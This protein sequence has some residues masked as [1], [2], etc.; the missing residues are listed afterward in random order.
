MKQMLVC[1]FMLLLLAGCGNSGAKPPEAREQNPAAPEVLEPAEPAAPAELSLYLE[2]EVYDPSLTR[3]T[4]FLENHTDKSVKFGEDYSIQFFSEDAWVDLRPRPSCGTDAIGYRISSG[5]TMALNCTLERYE[6]VP[7]PGRYR[8]VKQVDGHT[9]YAEFSLGESPYTAEAPYGFPPL[10]DLPG[11]YGADTTENNCVVF[12]GGGI[13]H[14]ET[15]ENFL[16]KV[17]LQA[18]CQ[19]RTV[20]D[21]GEGAP[22]VTDIIYEYGRFRWRLW[23]GGVITERYFP[24]IVTHGQDIYLS[25]GADWANSEKYGAQR[26]LLLPEGVTAEMCAAVEAMTEARRNSSLPCLQVFFSDGA[27][28][29]SLRNASAPTEFAVGYRLPEGNGAAGFCKSFDLQD[30]DGLETKV[31]NIQ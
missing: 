6:N 8:L 15:A 23:S 28:Y 2:R 4:Y 12:T 5:E 13:E 26:T 17:E 24:Y 11:S 18:H 25:D 9:L 21:Y 14:P 7:E 19:L 3:Y 31:K 30:W 16:R 20:Q 1:L 10:E 29:A 27:W 22:V